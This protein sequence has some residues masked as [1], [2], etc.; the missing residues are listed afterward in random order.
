MK[1]NEIE[2]QAEKLRDFVARGGGRVE[3]FESKDF[4]LG[5][6]L[7][8]NMAYRRKGRGENDECSCERE[9]DNFFK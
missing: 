5:E 2:Y 9:T 4:S 8:I 7:M 1:K 3:W 6:K